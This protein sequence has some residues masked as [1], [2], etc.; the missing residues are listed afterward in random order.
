[1]TSHNPQDVEEGYCGNCHD[2]TRQ[3]PDHRFARGCCDRPRSEHENTPEE[4][5]EW[6]EWAATEPGLE[7]KLERRE[8]QYRRLE[9]LDAPEIILA[10]Q[11]RIVNIVRRELGRP[12]MEGAEA[13]P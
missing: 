4:I 12:V 10:N 1:M 9:E 8:A 3:P 7:D 6:N 13:G 2:W 5:R 11:R